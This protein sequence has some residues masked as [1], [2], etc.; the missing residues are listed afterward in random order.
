MD[1]NT[2]VLS[3]RECPCLLFCRSRLTTVHA[4]ITVW[5]TE[6]VSGPNKRFRNVISFRLHLSQN[7][8]GKSHS[9]KKHLVMF[10]MGQII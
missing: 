1:I 3:E 9:H 6:E 5:H 7:S 8:V 2:D 10:K 4:Q